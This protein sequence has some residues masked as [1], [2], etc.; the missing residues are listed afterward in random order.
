[1]HDEGLTRV[2]FE[3][4]LALVGNVCRQAWVV[5]AGF[6]NPENSRIRRV[7]A[8]IRRGDKKRGQHY[9]KITDLV[10]RGQYGTAFLEEYVL[11]NSQRSPVTTDLYVD[12]LLYVVVH[13]FVLFVIFI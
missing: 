2:K 13:L 9:N 3:Y 11:Q 6:P 12:T 4:R 5:A 8:A 1:M 7:E 10:T